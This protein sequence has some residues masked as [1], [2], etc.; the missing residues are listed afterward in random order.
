MTVNR[1]WDP[2][3]ELAQTHRMMDRLFDG[4]FGPGGTAEPDGQTPAPTYLVPLDILETEDAYILEA[5]VPGF[6]PEKV[7]V[8]FDEGILTIQA[9]SEPVS[10]NG[11]WLRRERPRGNFQRK[12]Q[13]PTEV[14]GNRIAANFENGLL[15]VTVPKAAR[16]QPVKI[17]VSQAAGQARLAAAKN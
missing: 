3:N 11:Q 10:V 6:S 16:P 17:P 2:T 9:Q 7:E 5:A 15:T 8:T 13:L 12:L 4:F 14:Q 1:W